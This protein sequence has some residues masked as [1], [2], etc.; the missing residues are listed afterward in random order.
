MVRVQASRGELGRVVRRL[1]SALIT[2][3]LISMTIRSTLELD[4]D[5]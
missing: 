3:A 2:W 5:D 4:L 1:S